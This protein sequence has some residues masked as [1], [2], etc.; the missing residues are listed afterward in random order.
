MDIVLPARVPLAALG[1][2]MVQLAM[3]RRPAI[4]PPGTHD[5]QDGAWIIGRIGQAALDHDASLGE[6]GIA[7]GTLLHLQRRAV[8]EP[9]PLFDD[10]ID[11]VAVT[12]TARFAQWDAAA[13]RRVAA[14]VAVVCALAR[15]ALLVA[16]SL[17]VVSGPLRAAHGPPPARTLT[18]AL[19]ALGATVA[20]P[21]LTR[22]YAEPSAGAVAGFCGLPFAAAA[23]ALAPAARIG[24]PG[25]LLASVA[26][27]AAAAVCAHTGAAATTDRVALGV[28]TAA[29]GTAVLVGPTAAAALGG[30]PSGP[31]LGA[32]LMAAAVAALSVAPRLTVLL[33]RLPLPP[34]PSRD[35]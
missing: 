11:A 4:A 26:L 25:V 2:E 12:G 20:S 8:A 13:A 21:I 16:P 34:V 24:A 10:V 29:A 23:G 28:H 30:G 5:D 9:E 27:F 35:M 22:V 33:S 1:P 18:A 14:V 19:I 6:H 7:D 32:G 31:A 17:G 3:S 15:A